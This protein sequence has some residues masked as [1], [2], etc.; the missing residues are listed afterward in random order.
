MLTV[1]LLSLERPL[2]V[3]LCV[4]VHHASGRNAGHHYARTDASSITNACRS[5]ALPDSPVVGLSVP[6]ALLAPGA[7][8]TRL[9]TCSAGYRVARLGSRGRPSDFGVGG[10]KPM[11]KSS[12][13]LIETVSAAFRQHV[14]AWP[15]PDV[16]T[17]CICSLW[18]LFGP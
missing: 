10:W 5:P 1:F 12:P 2:E 14:K 16:V 7:M 17:H 8:T 18:V 9:I 6:L 15:G 11:I 4:I 3:D 13:I